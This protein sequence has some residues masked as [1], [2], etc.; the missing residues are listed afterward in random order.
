MADVSDYGPDHLPYRV[1]DN[2]ESTMRSPGSWLAAISCLAFV[3]EGTTGN[4]ES[5][6]Q[7]ELRNHN[8]RILFLPLEG[9]DHFSGLQK[10]S[11]ILAK[12][13]LAD[14]GL[15][16][17]LPVKGHLPRMPYGR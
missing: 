5:F 9:E 11:K 17:N 16:V 2:K 1:A 13:I 8:S 7:M 10:T 15:N 14:N 12:L 6:K 4:I 3:M